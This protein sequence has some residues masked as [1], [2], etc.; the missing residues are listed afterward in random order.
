M[1]TLDSIIIFIIGFLILF[2][3]QSI[4]MFFLPFSVGTIK[5]YTCKTSKDQEILIKQNDEIIR[6][7]NIMIQ[8]LVENKAVN[9]EILKKQR[10]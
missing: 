5:Q 1:I 7:N 4:M 8:L 6:Q 3:I 10:E 2:A 9:I